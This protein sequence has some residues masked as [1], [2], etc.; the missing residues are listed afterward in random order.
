[1]S[2]EDNVRLVKTT[3][4]ALADMSP[5]VDAYRTEGAR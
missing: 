4:V 2:I 5:I 1:M 3:M